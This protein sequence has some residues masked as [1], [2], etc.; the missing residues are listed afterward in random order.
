MGIRLS[1]EARRYLGA[2][3]DVTGARATDCVVDEEIV[4]VV[5]PDD[6]GRAIGP[7]GRTVDALEER[8]GRPIVL[9]EDAAHADVFAANALAPAAVYDVAIESREEGEVAV[10]TVDDAD[11]GVAIGRDGARIERARRLLDRHFEVADIE[12]RGADSTKDG[13]K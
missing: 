2:F 11:V 4:F 7:D 12:V 8:L 1:D 10:A 6:M 5:E 9:I 3:T 13:L